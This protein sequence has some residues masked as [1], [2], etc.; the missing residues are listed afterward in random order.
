MRPRH[1]L[2]PTTSERGLVMFMFPNHQMAR[3]IHNDR[4]REIEQILLNRIHNPEQVSRRS[5]RR[6]V[7][8]SL[9][10]VGLVLASDAPLQLSA[11]R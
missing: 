10:R 2:K 3:V 8:R 5:V 9:V 1:N 4:Q 7:G 6:S 11:R